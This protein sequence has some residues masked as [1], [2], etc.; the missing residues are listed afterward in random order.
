MVKKLYDSEVKLMELIWE[1]EPV[2]AKELS[3]AAAERI[4]WNKN[5]TY[6]VLKKLVDKGFVKRE[7]PGFVCTSLISRKDAE[8]DETRGLIDKLFHGSRKAFLAAF[9]ENESLDRDEISEIGEMIQQAE[10]R[11][12]QKGKN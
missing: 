7:E 6:T 9:L 12:E 10:E 11:M 8:K 5:T 1:S 4:G 2:T 3:L